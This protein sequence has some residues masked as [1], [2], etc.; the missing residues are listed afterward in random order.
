MSSR[1][2]HEDSQEGL[3]HVVHSVDLGINY[4]ITE[5]PIPTLSYTSY[6]HDLSLINYRH[7]LP[8]FRVLLQKTGPYQHC[9]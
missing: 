2:I 5:P 8:L 9:L 6:F 7:R 1:G 3:P 4:K